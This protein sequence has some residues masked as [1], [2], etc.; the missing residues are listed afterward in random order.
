MN[1]KQFA[2]VILASFI[3]GILGGVLSSRIFDAS[4]ADAKKKAPKVIEANEFRV[5]DAKGV[6]KASLGMIGNGTIASLELVSPDSP[7]RR[8][9]FNERALCFMNDKIPSVYLND[10]GLY[11]ENGQYRTNFNASGFDMDFARAERVSG[12][13][14]LQVGL[15]ADQAQPRGEYPGIRFFDRK[16]DERMLI[17]LLDS[18]APY[19]AL[20]DSV[21]KPRAVIGVTTLENSV[22]GALETRPASSIVLY[23]EKAFVTWKVPQ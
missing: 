23:D 11:F 2:L 22:S 21:Y 18:G 15:I 20:R 6:K 9:Y 4:V 10:R 3:G 8:V 13:P 17:H 16:K 7:D 5:V 19:I 1:R 14:L 12:I